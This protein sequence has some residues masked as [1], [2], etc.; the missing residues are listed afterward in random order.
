MLYK[1]VTTQVQANQQLWDHVTQ[2]V[3]MSPTAAGAAPLGGQ[4]GG[5][6]AIHIPKMMIDDDPE[7]FRKVFERFAW[8]A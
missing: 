3:K 5:R 7:P 2:S 1:L 8:V 6:P 4:M